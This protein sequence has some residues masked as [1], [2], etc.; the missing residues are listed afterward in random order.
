MENKRNRLQPLTTGDSDH[1][2]APGTLAVVSTALA[3]HG[4]CL[5]IPLRPIQRLGRGEGHPSS[6]FTTEATA[7]FGQP[8]GNE[9]GFDCDQRTGGTKKSRDLQATPVQ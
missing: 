4:C 7:R 9:L 1:A 5:P 2:A 3:P 6:K 8:L